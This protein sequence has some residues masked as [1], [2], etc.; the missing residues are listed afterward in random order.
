MKASKHLSETEPVPILITANTTVTVPR[1]EQCCCTE[2]YILCHMQHSGFCSSGVQL[3]SKSLEHTT[4]S[5]LYIF[6]F[7]FK[8]SNYSTVSIGVL[9]EDARDDD[10]SFQMLEVLIL[11]FLNSKREVVRQKLECL[12]LRFATLQLRIFS[13]CL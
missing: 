9:L 8:H 4:K 1:C 3:L 7:L 2:G 12:D 11:F 13:E 5:L 6:V 10:G